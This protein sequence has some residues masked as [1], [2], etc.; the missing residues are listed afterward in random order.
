MINAKIVQPAG[1]FDHG[2]DVGTVNK[3]RPPQDAPLILPAPKSA[4]NRLSVQRT[5]III[6]ALLVIQFVFRKRCYDITAASK[7]VISNNTPFVAKP[8]R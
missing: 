1:N 5:E 6:V 2:F 3:K 8:A 4:F 7:C